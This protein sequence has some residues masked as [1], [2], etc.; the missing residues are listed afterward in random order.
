MAETSKSTRSIHR[1]VSLRV[2]TISPLPEIRTL[3]AE[4]ELT[5][6]LRL[7]Q[8]M[9]KELAMYLLR[10]ILIDEPIDEIFVTLTG[11]SK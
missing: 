11:T 2:E 9:G 3:P 7:D 6:N 4:T 8:K 1:P 10:Q 5:I